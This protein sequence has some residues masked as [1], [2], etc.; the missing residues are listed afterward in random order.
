MAYFL[1]LN[2]LVM[3]TSIDLKFI[4]KPT[5]SGLTEAFFYVYSCSSK[6]YPFKLEH[7]FNFVLSAFI[8]SA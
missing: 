4:N 1:F 7:A 3:L 2:H 5:K 8:V 6:P